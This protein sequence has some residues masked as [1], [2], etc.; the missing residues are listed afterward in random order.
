[1]RSQ[2]GLPAFAGVRYQR[3]HGLGN[4]L[5]RLTKMALP[6]IKKNAKAIGK[7]VLETGINVVSDVAQGKS[8]KHAVKKRALENIKLERGPPGER[9]K[10]SRAKKGH[11]K[12]ATLKRMVIRRPA[13]QQSRRKDALT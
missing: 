11:K 7:K 3:G 8:L 12:Q 9:V 5:R 2:A 6:V 4:T 10:K 13:R 1:M